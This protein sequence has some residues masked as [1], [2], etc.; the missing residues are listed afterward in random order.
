[1]HPKP[2]PTDDERVQALWDRQYG[3][4]RPAAERVE[5]GRTAVPFGDLFRLV[6]AVWVCGLLITL[7]VAVLGFLAWAIA[8]GG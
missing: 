2:T 4:P 1:M 6:L 5:V 8:T 7:G 3:P